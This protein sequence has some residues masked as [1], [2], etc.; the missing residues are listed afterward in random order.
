MLIFSDCTL[1]YNSDDQTVW[2]EGKDGAQN[3]APEEIHLLIL[4][5]LIAS[6]ENYDCKPEGCEREKRLANEL[7]TF[8]DGGE[9]AEE[10]AKWGEEYRVNFDTIKSQALGYFALVEKEK[11]RK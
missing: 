7:H 8:V 11:N 10:L 9:I 4:Q 5:T 2:I 1:G 6:Q 3:F